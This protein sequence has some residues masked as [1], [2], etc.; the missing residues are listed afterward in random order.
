MQNMSWNRC[1]EEWTHLR[2]SLQ[3][4]NT[5]TLFFG[6]RWKKLGL[7]DIFKSIYTLGTSREDQ[8][9]LHWNAKG[10]KW[11]GWAGPL[12]WPLRPYGLG[13]FPYSFSSYFPPSFLLC[14]S[15]PLRLCYSYVPLFFNHFIYSMLFHLSRTLF[16]TLQLLG[17]CHLPEKYSVCRQSTVDSSLATQY[18]LP[19]NS[20]ISPPRINHSFHSYNDA[21]LFISSHLHCKHRGSGQDEAHQIGQ[22]YKNHQIS[23]RG[24]FAI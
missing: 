5:S 13:Q 9:T 2:T 20:A 18:V 16:L 8:I 22:F 23:H 3:N 10:R 15:L 7:G 4:N 24:L 11:P 19:P 21:C 17:Q 12:P 14:L 6:R 1:P